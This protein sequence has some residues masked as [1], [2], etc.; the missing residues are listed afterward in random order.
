MRL[1]VLILAFVSLGACVER[2]AFPEKEFRKL[3]AQCG[4]KA[5][6]YTPG[7]NFWSKHVSRAA[8][9][10][11]SKEKN[12]KAAAECFD[13]AVIDNPEAGEVGVTYTWDTVE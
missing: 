4:L 8:L 5:T 9:I 10:D 13:Q 12:P 7:Y 2:K 3:A 11:F 6:T 1:L